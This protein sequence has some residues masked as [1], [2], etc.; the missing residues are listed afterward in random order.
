MNAFELFVK[1]LELEGVQYIFGMPGE[2]N[3]AFLDARSRASQIRL[4]RTFIA[5]RK[6]AMLGRM[7]E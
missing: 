6:R 3:L 7:S 1:A 2:E 4:I 5:I